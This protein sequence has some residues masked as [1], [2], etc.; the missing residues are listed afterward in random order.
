MSN[1]NDIIER[2]LCSA[3]DMGNNSMKEFEIEINADVKV[4][5]LLIKYDNE[6]SCV[7]SKCT[8]YSVP[9]SMGVL[10][11]G[12]LRCM[13]HGAC[14]DVKTGDIEDYPGPDCLPTYNVLIVFTIL[15]YFEIYKNNRFCRFM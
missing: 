10:H 12:R 8:H 13:A 7:A 3:N 15:F 11:N 4:K 5:V 1:E 6:F 2:E 14:F 9:L